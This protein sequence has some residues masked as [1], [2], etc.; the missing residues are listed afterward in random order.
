VTDS[1]GLP[2]R[3]GDTDEGHADRLN[4]ELIELLNELRVVVPGIQVLFA[5]LLTVPFAE[6][7]NQ[8][9][10]EQRAV[11]FV[12]FVATALSSVTLL[13]VTS[14]HRLR[15]RAGAKEEL[16]QRANRLAIIGMLFLAVAIGSAVFL[17]TDFVYQNTSAAVVTGVIAVTIL[18]LWFAQPLIQRGRQG[19]SAG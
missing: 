6:R 4:R 15:W 5:F 18:W 9:S 11:Y 10:D 19:D 16:L 7:F 12:C 13:A 14:Q 1:A 8:V 3:S 2:G 17:V